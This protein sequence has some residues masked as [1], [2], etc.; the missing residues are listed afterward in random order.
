MPF[1]IHDGDEVY[2]TV[3]TTSAASPWVWI[4]FTV[5][6]QGMRIDLLDSKLIGAGDRI[7]MSRTE[8]PFA[9]G[10]GELLY[11]RVTGNGRMISATGIQAN[12]LDLEDIS[13]RQPDFTFG[14]PIRTNKW[15]AEDR[16]MNPRDAAFRRV[17][18]AAPTKLSPPDD[19][20]GATPDPNAETDR[21]MSIVG[22]D[23]VDPWLKEGWHDPNTAPA[24]YVHSE[25]G[26]TPAGKTLKANAPVTPALFTMSVDPQIA[27]YLGL[28]T[29]VGF[30]ETA[31][32]D[33]KNVWLIASRWAVQENRVVR[34]ID[35]AISSV[36]PISGSAASVRLSAFLGSAASL[37]PFVNTILDG[38]FPD[39]PGILARL[40][41]VPDHE[42][43]GRWTA[44]TLMALAIAPGDAPPDP[45]DRFQLS[46]YQPGSWNAQANPDAPGPESW[47]Q[48]ISLGTRPARGM[49]GFA[50]MSPGEPVALHQIVPPAGQ[51][52]ARVLPLV[53]NWASNNQRIV[54]DRFVP[55]DPAGTSWQVWQADE[56]GQWSDGAPFAAPLAARPLPPVPVAEAT[57]TALPDDHSGGLRVP[58]TISLSVEVPTLAKS[59]PGSLPVKTLEVTVDGLLQPSITATPGATFRRDFQPRPFDVG[60][61]RPVTIT[62]TYADSGNHASPA[63]T[64]QCG[65]FDARAPK[66]VPT[67]P[68]VIWAGQPDATGQAELALRW[69][70]QPGAARYRIYLG[71][72]RRLAGAAS[73]QPSGSA[74]RA[75][76]AKPIHD[77]SASFADKH[78]FTFLG[79]TSGTPEADGKIH[80][81][82]RIPASLRG[83]QFVRVVPLSHGGAEASFAHCGLVP[84]AIPGTDRPAPPAVQ[85]LADPA[86]G[87]AVTVRARGLRQDLLNAGAGKPP[88]YRIRRT[89]NA[90]A[91]RDYIPLQPEGGTLTGPDADGAWKAAFTTPSAKLDPFVRYRWFAEVRYPPEPPLP[92]E[93]LPERV[94]G[95]IEP[96]WTTLGSE[97][98]ALWSDPSLVAESLLIPNHGPQP[99]ETPTVSKHADGSTEIH[100]H[101]L[102]EAAPGAIGPYQLEIYRVH[103]AAPPTLIAATAPSAGQVSWTDTAPPPPTDRYALVVVDPIG[104]RSPP[105]LADPPPP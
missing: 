54:N 56:F 72:L 43:N 47:R 23:L 26:Q 93:T 86:S 15:Y 69:P 68:L 3:L 33:Q 78:L 103:G 85:A 18:A 53:P 76:D 37:P 88:Q 71:D 8:K 96:I 27:R 38:R 6:N 61:H 67:S 17:R 102:P 82:T 5:E 11:F 73:M 30:D 70:P 24:V 90:D 32:M 81:S 101:N 2:G 75:A 12:T 42:G 80:Y 35:E 84:V 4:E 63:Q 7:L 10:D 36:I 92:P 77:L 19:L 29:M 83:L 49:V 28:A 64:L 95:G 20:I 87:V 21:I 46:A 79:E 50:R 39:T 91:K 25:P 94:D 66:V 31:A 41:N 104:R 97:S 100:V 89:R 62:A 22:P 60:E 51:P 59:A 1:T 57:Y 55:P 48:S 9:F 44:V 58:G 52:T 34:K 99:P 98:E 105:T 40:P 14:L 16:Q 74:V 45:P 65:V 13:D